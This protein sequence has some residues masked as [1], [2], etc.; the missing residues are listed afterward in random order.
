MGNVGSGPVL[1]ENIAI[2]III[3]AIAVFALY[4]L[5]YRRGAIPGF[6]RYGGITIGSLTGALTGLILGVLLNP[7]FSLV[8]AA[9]IGML[10][11][12]AGDLLT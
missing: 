9:L 3:V 7:P 2:G 1:S 10:G 11:A 5:G 8:F 4:T 6:S 12:A